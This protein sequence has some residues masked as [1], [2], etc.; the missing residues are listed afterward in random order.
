MNVA[1]SAPSWRPAHVPENLLWDHNVI[2]F[3]SSFDDPF[4]GFADHVHAGPDI[5]YARGT[6]RGEPGWLLTRHAHIEE[7]HLRPELFSSDNWGQTRELLGVDW[8]MNPLEIDRPAH[9]A[10]RL[11]LQPWFTPRAIAKLEPMVRQVCR[12]LIAKLED[13]DGCEFISEFA[14]LFPS[15]IFLELMGMPRERLPD[16]MK[17]EKMF[18]RAKDNA[19]RIAG[20]TAMSDYLTAYAAE[21]R[22]NPGDDLVSAIVTAKIGDRLLN[23][24]EVMG[25][26][27]NLYAGGLDTVL[28]SLGWYFR[29]LAGDQALQ[30]RLR[31]NPQDIPAAVEE[32]LRAFGITSDRRIVTQDCEFH[33]VAMKKGDWVSLPTSLAGRDP[34]EWPNPHVIDVDRHPRHVTLARGVHVCL[35]MHLARREIK[36]V[37]QEF[38]SRFSNIRIPDGE[39]PRWNLQG[40]WGVQYLPLIWDRNAS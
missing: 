26:T 37:L 33:G 25:M 32:F 2:E 13:R 18:I 35:G 9:T 30:E 31:A 29:H 21:K 36:I 24:G 6:L 8:V 16:F 40:V 34:R 17:W 1:V 15:Y 3:A 14:Q 7:A 23:H 28:S 10:Y 20:L 19:E 39:A 12:E 11:I 27:M 38:L 22:A 4:V 5:V